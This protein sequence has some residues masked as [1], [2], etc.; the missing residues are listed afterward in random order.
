MPGRH[1]ERKSMASWC[2]IYTPPLFDKKFL[3]ERGETGREKK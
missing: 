3:V 1:I 2:I